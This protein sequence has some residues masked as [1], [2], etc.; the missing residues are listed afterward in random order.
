M[1]P[2][3]ARSAILSPP[4]CHLAH[5]PA[6]RQWIAPQVYVSAR[7]SHPTMPSRECVYRDGTD[8]QQTYAATVIGLIFSS[9]LIA[10]LY[11]SACFCLYL[12]AP[13]Q[14]PRDP[15][16]SQRVSSKIPTLASSPSAPPHFA[17]RVSLVL[18]T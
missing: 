13:P 14:P 3:P 18:T 7:Q 5:C 2:A 6:G 16:R 8:K 12:S 17:V 1:L 9:I 4:L 15:G 11:L 10:P